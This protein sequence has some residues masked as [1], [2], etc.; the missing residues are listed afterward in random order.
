MLIAAGNHVPVM[1]FVEVAGSTGA[2]LFWHSGFIAVNA[3]VTGAVIVI[4][5]V[6]VDA[7]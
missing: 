3:G 6:A 2:A 4:T 1:P 7:H 5:I